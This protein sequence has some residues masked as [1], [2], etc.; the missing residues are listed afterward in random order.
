MENVEFCTSV[1]VI[2]SSRVALSQHLQSFFAKL[3]VGDDTVYTTGESDGGHR[4]V[5]QLDVR[6]HGG[7]GGRVRRDGYRC[8]PA[9]GTTSQHLY[10]RLGEDLRQCRRPT[11]RRGLRQPFTLTKLPEAMIPT[12]FTTQH[13]VRVGSQ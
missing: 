6:Q 10:R 8:V 2:N 13:F 4:R 7:V 3:S 9:G 11:L 5:L 1:A 12:A